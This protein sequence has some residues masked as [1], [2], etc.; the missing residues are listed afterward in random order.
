MNFKDVITKTID[1]FIETI[2]SNDLHK[3]SADIL[4][5]N[6]DKNIVIFEICKKSGYH[7]SDWQSEIWCDIERIPVARAGFRCNIQSRTCHLAR[8][9][10]LLDTIS[11]LVEDHWQEM[12]KA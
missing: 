7:R 8:Y 3:F 4:S 11:R 2:N 9:A 10:S 6:V 5:I 1:E 12:E